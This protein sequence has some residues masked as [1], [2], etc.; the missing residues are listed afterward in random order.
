MEQEQ[1]L[2]NVVTFEKIKQTENLVK[3]RLICSVI[4]LASCL[5]IIIIYAMLLIQSKCYQ[6]KRKKRISTGNNSSNN[7]S[8]QSST[9]SSSEKKPKDLKKFN[10]QKGFGLGSHS[11]FF[12][13]F[14]N[15]LWCINTIVTSAYYPKGFLF[16]LDNYTTFC[17][18]F[19]FFHNYFDLCSIGWTVVISFLFLSSTKS[20]AY[21]QREEKKTFRLGMIISFAVPLF[22]TLC[23]FYSA[24]YGPS[25][26]YCSFDKVNL[27]T[28]TQAWSIIVQ[29]Y[30]AVGIF[31]CCYAIIRVAC[32]Y[33]GKLKLVKEHN[34]QE[35]S[36][37]KWYVI[38]FIL[39]PV[40]LSLSR[41][42][43]LINWTVEFFSKEKD[44]IVI[45]Y[46]YSITYCLNGF[47]NSFLCLFFFRRV[48]KCGC[49]GN[50]NKTGRT[51]SQSEMQINESGTYNEL[52]SK[53]GNDSD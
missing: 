36:V 17:A 41:L 10:S 14:S 13:V 45:L 42:V 30:P 1:Y 5:T 52:L 29:I 34:K 23:P 4:S 21:T 44:N 6:I 3:T 7:Q 31:Y 22:I 15:L 53:E 24:S 38:I 9:S 32:F 16:I 49:C 27:T 40:F 12:L 51:E 35:Y 46:L 2:K 39:F 50:E 20:K 43:K 48:L 11:M 33:S 19:G 25:G 47:F 8:F 26:A 28:M 18:L 37:L